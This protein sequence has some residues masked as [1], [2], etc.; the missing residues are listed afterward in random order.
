MRQPEPITATPLISQGVRHGFLTRVGGVSE[1]AFESLN[2][3][4]GSGD[5]TDRVARNRAR[6]VEESTG[7]AIPLV[8]VRQTHTAIPHLVEQPWDPADAPVG[9]ALVTRR[10][11]LA[12]GVLAADC[13]PVLLADAEAGVI[14]AAHAGWK[15]AFG[16]VVEAAIALMIEQGAE[17]ARISATVGPCIAQSSYEV[18]PEFVVRF[19]A[20]DAA[21]V[22]FFRASVRSGHSMFDLPGYVAHR[23]VRAGIGTVAQTGGDTCAEGSRFFSYRRM[24]LEGGTAYGRGVSV[25]ALV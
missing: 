2:C 23:L 20:A 14:G 15:G 9:D 21:N 16:G 4:F 18:G 10:E 7:R 24:T 1:G 3:G 6:A 22:R 17:R 13:A 25:I 5:E 19:A 12:L 11:G 8:T